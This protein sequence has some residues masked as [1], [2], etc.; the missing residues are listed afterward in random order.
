MRILVWCFLC[1]IAFSEDIEVKLLF[2]F[3]SVAGGIDGMF[4]IIYFSL[5]TESIASMLSVSW[6]LTS[7]SILQWCGI[8]VVIRGSLISIHFL[9]LC[10][11]VPVNRAKTVFLRYVFLCWLTLCL[12]AS[13]QNGSFLCEGVPG[14]FYS[15][16]IYL[17]GCLVW[18]FFFL[19]GYSDMCLFLG[20]GVGCGVTNGIGINL[21]SVCFF[22]FWLF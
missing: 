19:V 4:L 11:V 10:S 22:R 9:V 2:S 3:G 21:K 12:T 14:F 8:N 1:L 15:C 6:I 13:F 20:V 17:M 18:Y 7:F 16:Y 5:S